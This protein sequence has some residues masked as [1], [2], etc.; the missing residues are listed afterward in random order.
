MRVRVLGV[1]LATMLLPAAAGT[2]V[3][4]EPAVARTAEGYVWNEMKGEK[5]LALRAKGDAARGE[6]AFEVCRGCHR[7]GGSGREDGSYP[8]LSGQHASVLIK[9]ITDI[10]A[11]RRAVPKMLPFANDH[12]ASPQDIADIA[13]YLQNRPRPV[14]H[15]QGPGNDLERG[16]RLYLDDCAVC[17]GDDGEG[18][19]KEFFPRLTGQHYRYLLHESKAIRDGDRTNRHLRMVEAV[20]RYSDADLEVVSDYVSR[21]PER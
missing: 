1:A 3:A 6:V 10:R 21:L 20:K 4:A 8:R 19:A 9:Q 13:L 15:G 18:D 2:G 11:S 12:V 7:D 16:R 14:A 17:H 5:L